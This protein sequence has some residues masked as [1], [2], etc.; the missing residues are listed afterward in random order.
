MVE[1]RSPITGPTRKPTTTAATPVKTT[2][3]SAALAL[4]PTPGMNATPTVAASR[5]CATGLLLP[6]TPMPAPMTTKIAAATLRHGARV[7]GQA[8][9]LKARCMSNAMLASKLF[10]RTK[11]EKARNTTP[12]LADHVNLAYRP[13]SSLQ[14]AND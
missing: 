1:K 7:L 14:L 13:Y 3:R 10:G 4:P 8:A 2:A 6:E 9:T 5:S 12:D 11:V